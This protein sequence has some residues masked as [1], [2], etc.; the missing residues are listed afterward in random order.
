MAKKNILYVICLTIAL[1]VFWG[2]ENMASLFHGPKPEKE[3]PVYTIT[4]DANGATSGSAPAPLTA[5]IETPVTL[6][7][8]GALGFSGKIF[9]GWSVSPSGAGATYIAGY[10]FTVTGDQ[11]LYARWVAVGEAQQ[12]T[13]SF[14]GNGATGGAPP[15]PQTV[16]RG[17]SI[18]IPDKGNLVNTGKNFAGWNSAADGTG[19]TYSAGD[20]LAVSANLTLHAQWLDPS[21]QRYTVTY[22]ANGAGGA[23]PATQT[24]NEGSSITLPGAGSLTY[25]GKIF[26]GWNTTA[27]GSGTV[28]AAGAGFTV[29]AATNFYAQW[30]NEPVTPPGASLAEKFAYIAG[31]AD[32]GTV[33]D[34]VVTQNEYLGP[35]TIATQG[36]NVTVNLQSADAGDIKTVQIMSTGTLLTVSNNITLNLQDITL[37]GRPGND[38]VLVKVALGGV[39]VMNQN[40]KICDNTISKNT[41]T[42]GGLCI[43][44]GT[45]TM[46]DGEISG[47][48]VNWIGGGV[49]VTNSGAMVINGGRITGNSAYDGGGIL[50]G[51]DSNVTMHGGEISNNNAGRTGGGISMWYGGRFAKTSISVDG[52]SGVIYGSSAG[53]GLANTASNAGAAIYGPTNRDDTLG[54]F[55]E[56]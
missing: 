26:N 13:V 23:P 39:M 16:Y 31:R 50:I 12:Y 14:S 21:V 49:H 5:E 52:K 40:A 4:F 56:Y 43:D 19:T 22:H 36:R 8:E 51:Q 17:I 38:T 25:S 7:G 41:T 46:T 2:C 48:A 53:A 9:T 24:V 11:T 18:T 55:D 37:K 27:N 33:Y 29:N 44:G 34:I 15:A 6:P 32:D 28:Y 20:T 45:V 3:K 1:T 42:G 30:L 35:T 54:Q 10:S 47:N